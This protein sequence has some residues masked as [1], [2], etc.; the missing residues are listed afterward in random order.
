MTRNVS[1]YPL[2]RHKMYSRLEEC[3]DGKCFNDVLFTGETGNSGI[4]DI[5]TSNHIEITN[6]PDVDVMDLHDI[7]TCSFDAIVSDQVIEHVLNPHVAVDEMYRVLKP[8][9][10]L[11]L[12]T[13]LMNPI[14]YD[15]REGEIYNDY[16]RFTPSGLRVLCD[17][18]KTIHMC[19]GMGDFKLLFYCTDGHRQSRNLP[20]MSS[21]VNGDDGRTY[22]HVYVVAEK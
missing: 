15:H 4:I 16:W 10:W 21:I 13:C 3:L 22:I 11:I 14:H 18:F 19:E 8:G 5:I 17:K 20:E 6:Y 12:T 9:G 1:N 7:A 2:S